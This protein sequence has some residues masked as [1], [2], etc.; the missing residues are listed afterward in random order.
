[1]FEQSVSD[2]RVNGVW[3]EFVLWKDFDLNRNDL[4]SLSNKD[5][6][7]RVYFSGCLARKRK[8]KRVEM[9]LSN[10]W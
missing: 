3:E 9:E 8:Q 1:M 2:V 4:K 7:L 5:K 10:R 6:K